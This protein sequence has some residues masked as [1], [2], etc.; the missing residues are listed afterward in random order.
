MFI[1][2]FAGHETTSI[3][4]SFALYELALQPDL[5]EKL[6][7]EIKKAREANHGVMDYDTLKNIAYLEM[8]ISGRFCRI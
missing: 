8:V 1:F 5:Q 3:A 2:Y 6:R 4:L 7:Q